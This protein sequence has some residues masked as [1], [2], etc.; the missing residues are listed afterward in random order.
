MESQ[1][2]FS[3]LPHEAGTNEYGPFHRL[4]CAHVNEKMC[5][6]GRIGGDHSYG[7]GFRRV[8]AYAGPLPE[9]EDGIE[10]W[11]S[12]LPDRGTP[13]QFAYWSDGS[14]GVSSLDLGDR[15]IVAIVA[16]IV[17]RVDSYAYCRCKA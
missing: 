16:T 6:S 2:V 14:E 17:K 9:G 3:R 12:V 13:P 5:A 15:E 1:L 4:Q 8:H 10:F 7:V 11:T